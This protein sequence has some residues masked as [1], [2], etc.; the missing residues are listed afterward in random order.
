MD[1]KPIVITIDVA[2]EQDV[3]TII[4]HPSK[5]EPQ[6]ISVWLKDYKFGD[7]TLEDCIKVIVEQV[8]TILKHAGYEDRKRTPQIGDAVSFKKSIGDIQSGD[9]GTIVAIESDRPYPY[10][11]KVRD[12]E[13]FAKVDDFDLI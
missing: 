10:M 8:T 6:K 2:T 13:I 1:A 12:T 3:M 5:R 4:I 7:V 11:V 9:E